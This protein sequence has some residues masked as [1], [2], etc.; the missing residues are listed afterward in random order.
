MGTMGEV[1]VLNGHRE[2]VAWLIAS[3]EEKKTMSVSNSHRG[4]V[5]D[6]PD[7]GPAHKGGSRTPN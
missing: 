2:K 3:R 5:W 7:G 1:V 6:V 4:L